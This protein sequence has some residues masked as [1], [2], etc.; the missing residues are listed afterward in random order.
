MA[1]PWGEPA[2]HLQEATPMNTA[3]SKFSKSPITQA[4]SISPG[5]SPKIYRSSGS[6]K[7]YLDFSG[8]WRER[9]ISQ[10]PNEAGI[11]CVYKSQYFRSNGKV[12][13]NQLLYIGEGVRVRDRLL[14]HEQK[15]NWRS[16]LRQGEELCFS[17]API[18][19]DRERV[20]AALIFRHKPWA[21]DEHRFRFPYPETEVSL[22][23]KI[24]LLWISFLAISPRPQMD[25]F[26]EESFGLVSA[27]K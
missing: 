25:V 11:Y 4:A 3:V 19:L 16:R 24:L 18:I 14:T 22:S 15:E 27:A 5:I 7:F 21:N 10:I 20:R 26:Y 6:N 12:V 13:P 8:Y 23:G 2:G 1:N 9:E 17:F